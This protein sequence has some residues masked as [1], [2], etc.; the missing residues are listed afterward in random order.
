MQYAFK[1]FDISFADP[2]RIFVVLFN[3]FH[4]QIFQCIKIYLTQFYKLRALVTLLGDYKSNSS[5]SLFNVD[6]YYMKSKV[7]VKNRGGFSIDH[8]MRK[9]DIT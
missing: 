3:I 6:N 5:Y 1:G 7:I 4:R 9:Y 8:I 2:K